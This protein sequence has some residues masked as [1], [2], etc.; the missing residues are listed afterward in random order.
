MPQKIDIETVT[1]QVNEAANKPDGFGVGLIEDCLCIPEP[2]F[3]CQMLKMVL[4]RQQK[5][6]FNHSR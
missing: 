1:C 3:L 5:A 4:K 2:V 6:A